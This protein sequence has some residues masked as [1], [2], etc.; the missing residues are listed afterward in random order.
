MLFNEANAN[1][2]SPILM[3]R[4]VLHLE[5]SLDHIEMFACW[6]ARASIALIDVISISHQLEQWSSKAKTI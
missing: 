4:P 2:K 5:V 6:T 3:T 1:Y